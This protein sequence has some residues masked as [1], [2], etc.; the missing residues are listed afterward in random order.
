M[1]KCKLESCQKPFKPMRSIQVYCGK[2]CKV[3]F[4]RIKDIGRNRNTPPTGRKP[5][6]CFVEECRKVFIPQNSRQIYCGPDC[7]NEVKAVRDKIR[8]AK[9]NARKGPKVKKVREMKVRDDIQCKAPGCT[10]VFTPKGCRDKYCGKE[11]A[12]E[13]RRVAELARQQRPEVRKAKVEAARKRKD[14]PEP[15]ELKTL[16]PEFY[17]LVRPKV[18][19]KTRTCLKCSRRFEG[20]E[21][22]ICAACHA[23]NGRVSHMAANRFEVPDSV[24]MGYKYA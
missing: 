16:Y 14:N 8:V 6:E 13:V 20:A 18:K 19:A 12:N 21:Y 3:E 17:A 11:C 10:K 4:E 9:A 15:A 2:P 23:V 22:R 5:R 1:K 24:H 7:R